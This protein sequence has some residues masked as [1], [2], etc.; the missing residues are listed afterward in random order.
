MTSV[1]ALDQTTLDY[2]GGAYETTVETSV[3]KKYYA[4]AGMTVAV[5]HCLLQQGQA[6]G[7]SMKYLLTDHASTGSAQV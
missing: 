3:V 5:T 7:N 6:D 1:L 4:I 2:I